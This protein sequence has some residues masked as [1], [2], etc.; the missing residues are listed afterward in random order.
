M[1][2]HSRTTSAPKDLVSRHED[3]VCEFEA[4]G[5]FCAHID[6]PDALANLRAAT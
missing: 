3:V 2:K 1:Q 4:G 5:A 6:T